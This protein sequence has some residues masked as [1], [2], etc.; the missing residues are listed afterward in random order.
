MFW[1]LTWDLL[2]FQNL[3]KPTRLRKKANVYY[4]YCFYLKRKLHIT[5]KIITKGA[6]LATI[7]DSLTAQEFTNWEWNNEFPFLL[8]FLTSSQKSQSSRVSP[9][10]SF[11]GDL[12]YHLCQEDIN[13]HCVAITSNNWN[14]Q[15]LKDFSER[16]RV[17]RKKMGS[18]KESTTNIW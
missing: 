7:S 12:Q 5:S 8:W 11:L 4:F 18:Q 14:L 6:I 17:D 10:A 16:E 13:V 1:K 3:L 9:E 2:Q 15:L